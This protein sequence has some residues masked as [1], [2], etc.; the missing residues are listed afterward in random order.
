MSWVCPT[1]ILQP[2]RGP[3][4][5]NPIIKNSLFGTPES[6]EALDSYIQALDPEDRALAYTIAMMA[7]NLCH[8]RVE[9]AAADAKGSW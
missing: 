3:K 2:A 7:M 4:V 8:Q 9:D 6:Y 1:T 5:N